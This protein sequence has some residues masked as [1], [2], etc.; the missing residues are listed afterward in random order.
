MLN[1]HSVIWPAM[2][3]RLLCCLTFNT[4]DKAGRNK[5]NKSTVPTTRS[6]ARATPAEDKSQQAAEKPENVSPYDLPPPGPGL[7]PQIFTDLN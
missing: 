2:W 3:M 7:F 6:V 5:L 4:M 1:L